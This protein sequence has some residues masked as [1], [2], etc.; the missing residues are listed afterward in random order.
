M[1]EEGAKRS[2]S[3]CVF[4]RK[5][6]RTHEAYKKNSLFTILSRLDVTVSNST[7]RGPFWKQTVAYPAKKFTAFIKSNLLLI[8]LILKDST[9][10]EV[11]LCDQPI[12]ESKFIA[13]LIANNFKSVFNTSFADVYSPVVSR[14]IK[15]L[16]LSKC[17]G[18]VLFH[19]LLLRAVL[20]P[21]FHRFRVF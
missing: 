21:S 7:M 13:D 18:S 15:T 17:V 9:S 1:Q 2:V 16:N 3:I 12:T 19:H 14:A 4:Q 20:T 8:L 11:K 10:L 5:T 6:Q